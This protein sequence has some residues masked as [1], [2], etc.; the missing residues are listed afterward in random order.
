MKRTMNNNE[1]YTKDLFEACSIIAVG[2]RLL[3]L[4][5]GEG[6]YWFVFD[7]KKA[8]EVS[9]KYWKGELQVDALVYSDTF[10]RLKK[11]L[12]IEKQ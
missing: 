8:K 2:I 9:N 12:F 1:F 4:D 3:R 7:G 5:T 10:H 11:R 6:F